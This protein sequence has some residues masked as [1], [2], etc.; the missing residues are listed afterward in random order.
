[1]IENEAKRRVSELKQSLLESDNPVNK[2]HDAMALGKKTMAPGVSRS[3]L[4]QDESNVSDAHVKDDDFIKRDKSIAITK[5]H[6]MLVDMLKMNIALTVKKKT[7]ESD[8]KDIADDELMKMAKDRKLDSYDFV[9]LQK[10]KNKA[11]VNFAQD[12]YS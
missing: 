4:A 6:D 10:M 5:N 1:L 11:V 9:L 8:L 12:I 3:S 2:M 7:V